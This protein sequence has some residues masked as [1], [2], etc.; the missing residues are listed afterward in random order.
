MAYKG[1]LPT[2]PPTQ[3]LHTRS[4]NV[5][6]HNRMEF[7]KVVRAARADDSKGKL[8]CKFVY[9]DQN[10]PTGSRPF[11]RHSD[12]TCLQ[13]TA[14]LAAAL[15]SIDWL[16]DSGSYYRPEEGIGANTLKLMNSWVDNPDQVSLL[17][18]LN[19]KP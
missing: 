3:M 14:T 9:P 10:V 11:D 19:P 7:L 8:T 18:T 17:Q 16:M 1:L 2:P 4:K 15:R 6:V 13:S 5:H 12:S